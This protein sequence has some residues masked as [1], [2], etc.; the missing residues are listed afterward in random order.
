MISRRALLKGIGA[1]SA[2]LVLPV[3]ACS[4]KST[5][6]KTTIRYCLN[7]STVSEG[8]SLV[9]RIEIAAK[10]GYDGI[11]LWV[12]DVKQYIAN[13]NSAASLKNLLDE[14]HLKV[15]NAI[16][17]A[18]WIVDDD[19]TRKAGFEQ[20]ESE[21]RMLA[22]IGCTR[23]AAPPAGAY[24]GELLNLDI[25]AQRY[26]ALIELGLKTGVMPQLE[27][28]GASDNMSRLAQALYVASAANHPQARVLADVFHLYRGHSDFDGLNV[29]SGAACDIFH[30]N[31]YPYA[32]APEQ[33]SD[34]DRVF[35]GAGVAPY[36]KIA[37][38][39]HQL[40]G[41]IVLSLELFNQEYWK[42]NPLEVA[43]EGLNRMKKIFA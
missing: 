31:D 38:W 28:W 23:V 21:M 8:N 5:G 7:T 6:D 16:G 43:S 37:A 22:E 20:M 42:R 13:G 10:A 4:G 40:G 15:E 25:V 30:I 11:E 29:L 9:D 26:R 34:S 18:E 14:R 19:D 1:A 39:V 41:E 2:G 35:P 33:L 17:F 27:I 32:A 12:S 3:A 24:S 36:D